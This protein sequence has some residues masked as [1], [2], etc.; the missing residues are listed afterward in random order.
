MSVTADIFQNY[1][2]SLKSLF[3]VTESLVK[4]KVKLQPYFQ[5]FGV[6]ALEK[7][8][9]DVYSTEDMSQYDF[10]LDTPKMLAEKRQKERH[11][12]SALPSLLTTGVLEG[13][14]HQTML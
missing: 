7:E 4:T 8:D 5:G 9:E 14:Q 12:K 1:E 13:K 6:G 3:L 11:S 10:A 2:L